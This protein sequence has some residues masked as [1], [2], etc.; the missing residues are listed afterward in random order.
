MKQSLPVIFWIHSPIA[1]E[2]FLSFQK[3]YTEGPVLPVT[4]RSMDLPN[5]IFTLGYPGLYQHQTA[6]QIDDCAKAIVNGLESLLEEYSNYVLAIPQSAQPYIEALI[7]SP[8]CRGYVYYDEGSACYGKNLLEKSAPVYHRYKM[9]ANEG[10]SL[11]AKLLQVDIEKIYARHRQGVPFFNFRNPKYLGCFS[12]FENAFP[13]QDPTLLPLPEIGAE[14]KEICQD[15][16]IVLANDLRNG[17]TSATEREAHVRNIS[18]LCGLLGG[19]VVVKAHPSDREIDIQTLIG[20]QV[21]MW[22][23]FCEQHMIDQ[24]REVAFLDFRLYVTRNN[25]TSLY[26]KNMGLINMLSI[27]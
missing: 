12:F 11:L 14:F 9:E 16:C 24:N 2:L 10:F 13:G 18:V 27:Y 6:I 22:S 1:Y 20:S 25:S 17:T 26:L 4:A 7:E 15:Y 5:A 23:G 3:T 8:Y 19:K 21:L